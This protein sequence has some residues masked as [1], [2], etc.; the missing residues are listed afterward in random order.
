LQSGF[1]TFLNALKGGVLNP[2]ARIKK[3]PDWEARFWKVV[4]VIGT[5]AS[6]TSLILDLMK[7]AG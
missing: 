4:A 1:N 6:L 2:S 7:L 5:V 3:P